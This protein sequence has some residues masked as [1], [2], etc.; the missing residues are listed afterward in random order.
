[1]LII[2]FMGLFF[3]QIIIKASVINQKRISF[4]KSG[5]KKKISLVKVLEIT[6]SRVKKKYR[7][8]RIT[9]FDISKKEYIYVL[10]IGK[11]YLQMFNS[12][13][14]KYIKTIKIKGQGFNLSL[15]TSPDGHVF[16]ADPGIGEIWEFDQNLYEMNTIFIPMPN[17]SINL[18][19]DK[20]GNFFFCY[21]G[22]GYMIHKFSPN[23][24]FIT[25]FATPPD[26]CHLFKTTEHFFNNYIKKQA[27]FGFVAVDDSD[28]VYYT[29]CNPYE[30]QKF[31]NDGS[32]LNKIQRNSDFFSPLND[33]IKLLEGDRVLFRQR[34]GSYSLLVSLKNGILINNLLRPTFAENE[35][36]VIH[37][38]SSLDFLDLNGNWLSSIYFDKRT[39]QG[40]KE[41]GNG[42]I[43]FLDRTNKP[44]IIKFSIKYE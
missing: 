11:R 26:M 29:H 32:L 36:D 20:S 2:L 16:V 21:P 14:G 41:D 28:N 4:V 34:G 17:R 6:Q 37:W 38:D 19:I 12:K 24:N 44:K 31:S 42:N 9:A 27:S 3:S 33:Y 22:N 15:A 8:H 18:V 43:Y 39:I 40:V 23:G 10:S 35:V 25:S 30:I 7:I 13:N 5:T 1:M